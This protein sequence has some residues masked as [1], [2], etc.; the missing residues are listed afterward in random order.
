MRKPANT[1]EVLVRP[2]TPK[3]GIPFIAYGDPSWLCDADG[4]YG[5]TAELVTWDER[6][7][8]FTREAYLNGR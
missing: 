8:A 7:G 6:F 2:T 5:W 1:T 4:K 3:M